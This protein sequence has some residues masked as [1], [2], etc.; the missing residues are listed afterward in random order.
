[1]NSFILLFENP[2]SCSFTAQGDQILCSTLQQWY[3]L[4]NY[5]GIGA[6]Y[7]KCVCSPVLL[8]FLDHTI[9]EVKMIELIWL[10]ESLVLE[11]YA[12]DDFKW[13]II[14]SLALQQ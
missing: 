8:W 2:P 11:L 14:I 5:I 10:S 13:K 4:E 7:L 3:S 1:M 9:D 6:V 12:L